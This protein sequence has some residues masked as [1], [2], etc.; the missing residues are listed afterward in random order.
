MTQPRD[1]NQHYKRISISHRMSRADVVECCRL[2]G[3]DITPS[4]AEGWSRGRSDTRRHVVMSGADFEAF[5]RG[6]VEWARQAY[7]S[8]D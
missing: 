8:A 4:R 5:T 3:L 1:W 7:R 6:L 2:G